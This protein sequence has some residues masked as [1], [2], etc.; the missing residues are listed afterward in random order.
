MRFQ[1]LPQKQ[2]RAMHTRRDIVDGEVED[3]RDVPRREPLDVAQ[4]HDGAVV[5]G[6]LLDGGAE[7][8]PKLDLASR[9]VDAH[10][11]VDDRR[12]VAAML[13][14]HGK[15]RV[16]RD[17]GAAGATPPATSEM[18]TVGTGRRL[19]A[20]GDDRLEHGLGTVPTTR[21]IRG[22]SVNADLMRTT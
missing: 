17:I 9:V 8:Y 4:Q 7:H 12:D 19:G 2:P 6:Q 22:F 13:I 15:R 5:G 18:P 3:R 1:L 20:R 16:Q 11:P 14:E 10:R 21:A